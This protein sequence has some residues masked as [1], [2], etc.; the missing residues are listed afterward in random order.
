MSKPTAF[1]GVVADLCDLITKIA[2][3][4]DSQLDHETVVE[5]RDEARALLAKI[6]SLEVF[7]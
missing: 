3:S 4:K 2:K 6:N 5:W 7:E 1:Q